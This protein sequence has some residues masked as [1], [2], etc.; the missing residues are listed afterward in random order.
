MSDEAITTEA[1]DA[2]E[3]PEFDAAL[4]QAKDLNFAG[5][6]DEP[7]PPAPNEPETTEKFEDELEK[8]DDEPEKEP[9]PE[10]VKRSKL[11]A[12][13]AR[14][15]GKLR[16]EQTA[17]AQERE[18]FEARKT[19][20]DKMS[21]RLAELQEMAKR[22]PVGLVTQLGGPEFM[23]QLSKQ[24]IHGE[25]PKQ[26]DPELV[27][28]RKELDELKAAR[29]ERQQQQEQQQETAK[30]HAVQRAGAALA[31]FVK[32]NEVEYP[33]VAA[34]GADEAAERLLGI[35]RKHYA[36]TF[37]PQAKRGVILDKAAAARQVEKELREQYQRFHEAV[38]KT[39]GAGKTA[40]TPPATGQ[41]P[42]TL[43]KSHGS[44]TTPLPANATDEQRLAAAA[45]LL[46][47]V[48]F[49]D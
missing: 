22:D 11:M 42:R 4:E 31:E 6:D 43:G 1:V 24:L 40:A 14:K 37:D 30:Q 47:Q 36:D 23:D 46:E 25:Q 34:L 2:N 39:E 29:A 19:E 44:R 20:V 26:A 49:P 27:A 32:S 18:A 38:R 13:L 28:M 41:A 16:E 8:K 3:D 48:D 10:E 12:S 15:E 45:E 9:T 7:E 17:F 33:L 21:S 35:T 5:F